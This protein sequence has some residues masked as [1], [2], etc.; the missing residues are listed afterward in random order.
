MFSKASLLTL[1]TLSL[2]AAANP[3]AK[4]DQG[5]RI[6]LRKRNT[7]TKEDGTFDFEAANS[8][9][10]QVKHKYR[11]NLINLERNVGKEAFN[12]VRLLLLF[13]RS[14]LLTKRCRRAQES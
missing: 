11:Q 7:F 2:L 10:A 1:V 8:H 3:V 13:I 4:R 9:T 12:E 14:F 5:V 6:P